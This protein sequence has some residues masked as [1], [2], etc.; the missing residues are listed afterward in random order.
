MRCDT[1]YLYIDRA[2]LTQLAV[3]QPGMCTIGFTKR[4]VMRTHPVTHRVLCDMSLQAL[5]VAQS[6]WLVAGS[7]R[8]ALKKIEELLT[9]RTDLRITGVLHQAVA[10]LAACPAGSAACAVCIAAL[11]LS[12]NLLF[13]SCAGTPS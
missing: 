7:S 4:I 8:G 13:T 3:L 6:P 1:V 2:F 9:A 10:R 12:N 11:R 5:A